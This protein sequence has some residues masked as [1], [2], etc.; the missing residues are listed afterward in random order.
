MGYS[1]SCPS[2]RTPP[3]CQGHF[4]WAHSVPQHSLR[5]PAPSSNAEDRRCR[6]GGLSVTRSE[7]H[8][9]AALT[10]G[11][12]WECAVFRR[13]RFVLGYGAAARRVC[14]RSKAESPLG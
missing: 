3:P 10:P 6:E 2:P 7:P 4:L 9:S 1:R 13:V 14:A 12:L 11:E 5:L 8:V